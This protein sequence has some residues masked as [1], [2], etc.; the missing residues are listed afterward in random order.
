MKYKK[1]SAAIISMLFIIGFVV[2]I[3]ASAFD[4]G[5]NPILILSADSS[6]AAYTGEILKTEGFNE[7]ELHSFNNASITSKQLK[8]FD[9]II[10]TSMQLHDNQAAVLIAY[11]K[12]G[13]N[14][15]VFMPEKKLYNLC[16]I[17]NCGGQSGATY[18]SIKNNT[19]IGNGLISKALQLHVSADKYVL[20]GGEVIASLYNNVSTPTEYPAVF[21]N[22]YGKGHVISFSYN[23]PQNISYTRQGNYRD[24][25]KE[26]DG[27]TG[28]RAMDLFT[29]GWVDT[30]DNTVNQADE[31]MRLLSHS[32]EKLSSYKK[33]LPRF[34]YFPDTLKCLVTLNNDGEDN[35]EA[36]FEKQ[37]EDVDAKG[38]KMTLYI[39]E[40]GFI[41]KD[42]VRRWAAKGFEM[43]GHPDDTKQATNPDWQTMDTVFKNLNKRLTT[44]YGIA[45]MR[46]VTNHWFVWCGKKVNG[47]PDFS[48]Q[49]QIEEQNGI[50]QDCNYAHYDNGSPQGHFLG[51]FGTNHGNY[52]GSGLTMKYA[53]LQGN[54]INVYQHFNN[55]YDQQYMEHDDK[56]G[57]YNCF[58]GLVDRSLD[59]EVYSYVSVKAHNA[60]YDF[61]EKPLMKMLD[62]ANNKGIPVW[63][64]EKLLDF[65]LAK[66]EASFNNITWKQNTISF[67]IHS[68][69]N[70]TNGITY[71]LPIIYSGKK[72]ASI[73]SN[74]VLQVFSSVSVKGTSY[75]WVTVRPGRDYTITATY[76]EN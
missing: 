28:I 65:L 36:D 62:Y 73:K 7:Y 6:Y 45:P 3:D 15:I 38:A 10:L 12:D 59:S 25:G 9:V 70:H 53:N 13:G 49:V 44:Q 57:F 69:L 18:I 40:V 54:V 51:P 61:S 23:L 32:I 56:D 64:E 76:S 20:K 50:L 4:K 8:K 30:A 52:T 29:G 5:T 33:P 35:K 63:T 55:V 17:E 26:M 34:W 37:F 48:A 24:A 71:M 47:L 41:S 14:L 11:V 67:K 1:Y 22:D 74:G 58:E 27:I 31:Q 42:W 2:S 60:E 19:V 75:A 43:S 21:T 66:D 39:K 16:G 46:T 68:T 72:I